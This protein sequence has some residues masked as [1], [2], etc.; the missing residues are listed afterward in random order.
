MTDDLERRLEQLGNT[1]VVPMS[2]TAVDELEARLLATRGRQVPWRP[3]L[4]TAA[5]L[6]LLAGAVFAAQRTNTDSLR[7]ATTAATST[8]ATTGTS[9]TTS[10]TV[11]G[12][13]TSV[14]TTV[15]PTTSDALTPQPT[16]PGGIPPTNPGTTSGAT[17]TTSAG[18]APPTSSPSVPTAPPTVP[19]TTQP[20]VVIPP[21]SFTLSVQRVGERLVFS[22]PAYTG[23]DGQQYVLVRVGPAGLNTWPVA[24]ARIATVVAR[25]NVTTTAII[26]PNTEQRRW[27]L[28][29]VGENR[30]LLAVS[31]VAISA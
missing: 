25:M 7:P 13:T 3:L 1:P 12:S 11:P 18:T 10:T 19:A 23:G 28:A 16:V 26:Q 24:P 4:A 17:P 14:A 8:V 29:V 20:P 5:A 30:T 22:W 21:A 31:S 27:V 15:A 6:L 2:V 9:S